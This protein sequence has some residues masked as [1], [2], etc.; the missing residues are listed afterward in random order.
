MLICIGNTDALPEDRVVERRAA[1]ARKNARLDATNSMVGV[2]NLRYT[3]NVPEAS[4]DETARLISGV[5]VEVQRAIETDHSSIGI[6]RAF[7]SAFLTVQSVSSKY[8]R[9]KFIRE[10][11]QPPVWCVVT[12][13]TSV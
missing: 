8:G 11:A 7:D 5:L 2:V 6:K 3:Y 10:L 9:R 1:V 4:L 13:V 12:H